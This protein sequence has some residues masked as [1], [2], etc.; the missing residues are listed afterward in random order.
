[1]A[2]QGGATVPTERYTNSVA[3]KFPTVNRTYQLESSINGRYKRDILPIN[4][5]LNTGGVESNYLEYVVGTNSEEFLDLDEITLQL[6]LKFKKDGQD[7][8]PADNFMPI[9]SLG[10]RVLSSLTAHI[11]GV[12]IENNQ[13]WGLCQTVECYTSMPKSSLPTIGRNM[14]LQDLDA[15]IPETINATSFGGGSLTRTTSAMKTEAEGLINMCIP[16]KLNI[17]SANFYLLSGCTMRLRFDLAIANLLINSHEGE[18]T[19]AIETAKLWVTKIIPDTSALL[20]LNRS[21][22]DGAS[23]ISYV[24]D[25]TVV[26]NF[27]FPAGHQNITME[28]CFLSVIPS[29][30]HMIILKQNALNGTVTC[31]AGHFANIGLTN[32]RLEVN[33]NNYFSLSSS[34]PRNV[35]NAFDS[36]LKNLKSDDN[37]LTLQSY[38]NG[39]TIYSFDLRSS[40]TTDVLNIDKSGNLRLSLQTDDPLTENYSILLIATT[41]GLLEIFG[42]RVCKTS[43]LI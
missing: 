40:N 11:N 43:F 31:N 20:S 41:S 7:I 5:S 12:C 27:I 15:A 42:N 13:F 38:R 30:L 6:S 36:T 8:T 24:H 26:K 4:S 23:A 1:M 29:F 2:F 21:L 10:F 34:F 16:I 35:A 33:G 25:R 32:V 37:L 14:F 28:N 3:E 22:T 39:R 17:S 9:D 18:F 19:Y